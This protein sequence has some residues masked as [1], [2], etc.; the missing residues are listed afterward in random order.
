M[1]EPQ[2]ELAGASSD[3]QVGV[4]PGAEVA[5]AAE[6]LRRR[7]ARR[8]ARVV[9]EQDRDAVLALEVAQR[10]KHG[11]DLCR[12]AL[13]DP[14]QAHEGIEHQQPR[15]ARGDRGREPLHLLASVEAELGYVEQEE[16]HAAQRDAALG[17]HALEASPQ[18]LRAVLN[19][20][21]E[22]RTRVADG[23]AAEGRA[24]AGD[25]QRQLGRDPGLAGLG[26]PAE[27]ADALSQPQLLGQPQP[28]RRDRLDVG[29]VA[30]ATASKASPAE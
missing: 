27:H 6:G 7:A 13:V 11:R 15:L 4:A 19:A 8:L 29:D 3:V 12:R 28:L 25:G 16:R 23:V 14:R 2:D 9:H 22:H 10:A 30:E 18:R 21:E 5:A 24:P 20:E 26:R 1:L 17:G